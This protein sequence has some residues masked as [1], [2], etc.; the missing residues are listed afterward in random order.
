[1]NEF[2]FTVVI[3]TLVV[4]YIWLDFTSPKESSTRMELNVLK[5]C[6]LPRHLNRKKAEMSSAADGF[7]MTLPHPLPGAP[8][9][10]SQAPGSLTTSGKQNGKVICSFAA[11]LQHNLYCFFPPLL[12]SKE[13]KSLLYPKEM[14]QVTAS[15]CSRFCL[16]HKSLN[17][18]FP[19]MASKS[20]AF[21]YK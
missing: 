18:T 8:P 21:K 5:T 3:I 1:M 10:P 16:M 14:P 12:K 15:Y 4:R 9:H 13:S 17:I 6:R 20:K 11:F 19:L 7:T 2:L